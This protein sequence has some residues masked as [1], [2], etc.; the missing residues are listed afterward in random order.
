MGARTI[1]GGVAAACL[2]VAC[3]TP[4]EYGPIGRKQNSGYGYKDRNLTETTWSILVVTPDAALSHDY[5]DHRARELCGHEGYRKNIFRAI[6]PTVAYE[7]Y[8]GRPGDF[9][10]EG[11][12]D[13]APAPAPPAAPPTP[14]APVP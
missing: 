1:L 12:L 4:L 3:V 6:R 14:A 11:Y 10:L 5:W 7:S 8:G 13:C 9:H 2:L